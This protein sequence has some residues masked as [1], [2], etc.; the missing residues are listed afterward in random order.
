MQMK[1]NN[2][3]RING[4]STSTPTMEGEVKNNKPNKNVGINKGWSMTERNW[5][6][7][8]FKEKLSISG[9]SPIK[10]VQKYINNE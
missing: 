2:V 5:A 3:S 4:V 9:Y 1:P 8:V 7:R 6:K 10:T